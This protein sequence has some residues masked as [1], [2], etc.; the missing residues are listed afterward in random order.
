MPK[1]TRILA[2]DCETTGLDLRH[3]AK[4][5]FLT[6]C[7]E[8]GE[9]H[10]WE[11][12]VDPLTR[13]PIW[14][15]ED[16]EEF[17][18]HCD[19]YDEWI[20]QNC[21]FDLTAESAIGLDSL[22]FDRIQDTLIAGHLLASNQPHDLTSMALIYLG[23]NI[24]PYEEE[25]KDAVAKARRIATKEFPEWKIAKKGMKEM[26]SAKEK[27]GSFDYWL[28]R[29]IAK[30]K[31]YPKQHEWWTVLRDYGNTDSI[32]T[33]NLWKVMKELLK[34]RDL[35][36]IYRERMRVVPV[37]HH[38]ENIGIT[39]HKGRMDEL[40]GEY[41]E[42]SQ[43]NA[44]VCVNIAKSLD[45]DLVLPKKGINNSLRTFCF[46]VLGLEKIVAHKSKSGNPTLNAKDA[47]PHYFATLP[48]HSKAY[49]FLRNLAD[50]GS[51]DT[52]VSYMLGY[53][54]F[55]KSLGIVDRNWFRLHPSL[56]ITGTDT[57]RWSSNNP[58]EQNISKKEGFNLRYMFG[59]APGREWWSR[60][61][62]NIELRLPAYEAK[63]QLLIDL[64]E[65]PDEPPYYG[66]EHIL[67]FSVVWPELWEQGIKEVGLKEVGPW[68]K[69]KYAA[70]NYQWTKNGD[71]AIQY[72]AVDRADG[73]GTA[74]KAFHKKGA[75]ALLRSRFSKKE[76]LN[77]YW[78]KFANKHG[79][80]ET[81]PDKSVNPKRGYPLLCQRTQWGGVKPT[82]PL[83]YHVQ[84]TA[85]WWMARAMVRVHEFLQDLNSKIKDVT[86]HYH[87]VMQV[88]DEL[89]LD[90]PKKYTAGAKQPYGNLGIIQEVGRLMEL[91]G[92]DL[93]VPTPTSGEYHA[94]SW[95]EGVS[96]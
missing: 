82:I 25:L 76:A 43:K 75:H 88:H 6:T 40:R 21:K 80:V 68:C 92:E 63:E 29:A 20:Y 73:N 42:T 55:W 62:K 45:Y 77:Q 59:P 35:W 26:P 4:P 65:K 41:L 11:A 56:N 94:V 90:F 34:E 60:D 79:Y 81:M 18:E 57:L 8:N 93:G 31:G 70:T 33:L 15:K 19:Q 28:P 44:R 32:V 30:A 52:A 3:G 37:G 61:A 38:M 1:L 36:E 66:S 47:M 17:E 48:K 53:E 23:V 13:T 96:V 54:K 50:K 64:F 72:G 58:N 27:V 12:D 83:S 86:K 7:D 67:N 14:A 22:K 89:V 71:F 24:K 95:S 74:D 5:F 87:I 78:I 9:N 51:R 49:H 91:G 85:M 84:G 2:K 69:K 46:D 10:F 16:L 39:L